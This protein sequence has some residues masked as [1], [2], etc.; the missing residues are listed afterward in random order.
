MIF[1]ELLINGDSAALAKRAYVAA[2]PPSG[3]Q[4]QY[5]F[6][7]YTVA[8]VL[9]KAKNIQDERISAEITLIKT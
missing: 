9:Y 4:M 1:V 6:E 3:A 2:I 5:E 8:H 7:T